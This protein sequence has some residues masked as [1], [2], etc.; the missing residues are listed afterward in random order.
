MPCR[1]VHSLA[2][3]K[4]EN[5]KERLREME[6]LRDEL[7]TLVNDW[8]ER[9]EENSKDEPVHLLEALS[10]SP[11]NISGNQTKHRFGKL[12]LTKNKRKT[13]K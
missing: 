7:E 10:A 11:E 4:L 9:L 2:A 1:T 12:S 5:V 6:M 8:V 13:N 3:S